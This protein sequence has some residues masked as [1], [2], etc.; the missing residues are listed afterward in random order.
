MESG[1]EIWNQLWWKLKL[2]GV[3]GGGGGGG[4]G[5]TAQRSLG[6]PSHAV[7]HIMVEKYF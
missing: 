7:E 4:G 3:P 1:M 6:I 2:M 5:A